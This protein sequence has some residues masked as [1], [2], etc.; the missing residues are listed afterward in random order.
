MSALLVIDAAA[1]AVAVGIVDVAD[2]SLR[3]ADTRILPRGQV[4]A[5]L[6]MIAAVQAQAGVAFTGLAAVAATVGPGSFTGIR[7]GLAAAR[8]IGLATGCPVF[9]VGSFAASLAAFRAASPGRG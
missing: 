9:G 6:P 5:L 7:L 1:G 2:G 3:A 8:G 4:E